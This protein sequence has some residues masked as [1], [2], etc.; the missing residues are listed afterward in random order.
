M[1]NGAVALFCWSTGAS[2]DEQMFVW[3]YTG[4]GLLNAMF[5]GYNFAENK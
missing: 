3:L 5:A 1:F 4:L 2:S